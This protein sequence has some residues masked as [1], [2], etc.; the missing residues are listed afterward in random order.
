MT[1]VNREVVPAKVFELWRALNPSHQ[2]VFFDD[3]DCEYC[4]EHF[5]GP[6]YL[7]HYRSIPHTAIRCDFFRVLLLYVYGGIYCDIDL[8]PR[9][10]L[11][12]VLDEHADLTFAS[13][14]ARNQTSLYQAFIATTPHNPI[15][16]QSVLE[17][18]RLYTTTAFDG[19]WIGN[20][21]G[22][23]VMF[24]A[25]QSVLGEPG[26]PMSRTRL[27]KGGVFSGGTGTRQRTVLLLT[28]STDGHVNRHDRVIFKTHWDDY[29]TW[30]SA[31]QQNLRNLAVST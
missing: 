17:F 26:E 24:R 13:C 27:D 2:I 12:S 9:V 1:Y 10:P 5:Y 6:T 25:L 22:T 4:V 23:N 18:V 29:R 16:A 28:E 30:V 31:Y 15:L 19:R 20:W 21:S 7:Q 11:S 3:A 8:V 14:I